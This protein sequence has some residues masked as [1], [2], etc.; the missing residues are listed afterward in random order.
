MNASGKKERLIAKTD[1][2][3]K[4]HRPAKERGDREQVKRQIIAAAQKLVETYG[5]I[6]N[7]NFGSAEKVIKY[8]DYRKAKKAYKKAAGDLLKGIPKPALLSVKQTFRQRDISEKTIGK[9]DTFKKK[10]DKK[11]KSQHWSG[12]S[13]LLAAALVAA[14][15][16]AWLYQ[17][18]LGLSFTPIIQICM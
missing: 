3:F 11:A 17:K 7:A 2:Y 5:K 1:R 16:A 12:C 14:A 18:Q 9:L 15:A 6:D 4:K 10:L 13:K 8:S